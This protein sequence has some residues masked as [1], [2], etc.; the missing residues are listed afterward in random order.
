MKGLAKPFLHKFSGL[1][2]GAGI[3]L[4]SQAQ[5]QAGSVYQTLLHSEELALQAQLDV[6][7]PTQYT[8]WACGACAAGAH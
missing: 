6:V 5:A 7:F 4:A 3:E 1:L 8:A 2:V